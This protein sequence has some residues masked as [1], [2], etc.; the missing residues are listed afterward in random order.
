MSERRPVEVFSPGEFIREELEARGWTQDDL[1]EILGRPLRTVNEIIT[2]KRGVTPE[3]AK[4]LGQALG[5]S[6]QLWMNLEASYRLSL[7]DSTH[8][9]VARRATLYAEAPVRHLVKRG[10]IEG[11][12]NID[13][14]ERRVR[15][16]LA[17][18]DIGQGAQPL[19]HTA[20]KS[21]SYETLTPL[22]K[23]WLVRAYQL[24]NAV[25]ADNYRKA[26]LA[27]VFRQLKAF[28]PN[29]EDTRRIPRLL[30]EAGIRFII[31][32]PLPQSK[33]DGASFWLNNSPV[34]A[35]S[36]RYDRLD[37]FWHT[38]VHELV[39]VKNEDGKSNEKFAIDTDLLGQGKRS[40][41]RRVGKECRS[42]WSTDH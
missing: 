16:F 29:P 15:D 14:L 2:G 35:L 12:S 5:T 36:L 11:S 6:A 42:R 13:V 38:L 8:E 23:A 3:T 41:E 39:H 20:R 34:L 19:A 26:R 25:S 33:I 10:W 27:D 4:G 28:L 9:M 31:I 1:A 30:A 32:E 7:A 37:W 17:F 22:Q 21:T 24:A 18:A 40:E